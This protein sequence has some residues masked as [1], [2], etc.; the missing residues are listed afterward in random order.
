MAHP[1]MI[2]PGPGPGARIISKKRHRQIL[3]G[4]WLY[5]AWLYEAWQKRAWLDGAIRRSKAGRKRHGMKQR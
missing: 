3:C 1:R 4:A 5:E 2:P